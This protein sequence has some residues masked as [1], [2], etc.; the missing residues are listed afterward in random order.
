[1]FLYTSLIYGRYNRIS[2]F[3]NEIQNE[4]LVDFVT[5]IF[6]SVDVDQFIQEEKAAHAMLSDG[7]RHMN[8]KFRFYS[9]Y[10]AD[11]RQGVSRSKIR[12]LLQ[13]FHDFYFAPSAM[14]LRKKSFQ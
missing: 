5:I 4:G 11:Q 10:L 2:I 1:M 6:F 8:H 12:N 14:N 3:W 9:D 7:L 13:V